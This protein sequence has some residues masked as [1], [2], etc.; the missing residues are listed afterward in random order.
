MS[1]FKKYQG[2]DKYHFRIYKRNGQ[3]PFV[4]VMITEEKEI[5]NHFL[6][7]GY[8]ITHSLAK[9]LKRPKSYIKLSKNPN[10]NDNSDC[11]LCTKRIS[12]IKDSRFSKPYN[13]WHLAKEDEELITSLESTKKDGN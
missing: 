4:V 3:H 9:A 13:N 7:S 2:D 10:P 6:I 12:S 8:M 5:N 1:K 11:F